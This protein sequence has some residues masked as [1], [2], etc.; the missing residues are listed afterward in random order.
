MKKGKKKEQTQR[1][2]IAKETF[3]KNYFAI[4]ILE[5]EGRIKIVALISNKMYVVSFSDID[6]KT[7]VA[8]C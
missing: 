8:V 6:W 3:S 1:V 2:R 5:R 7:P 4:H